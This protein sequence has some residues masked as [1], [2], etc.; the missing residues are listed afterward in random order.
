MKARVVEQWCWENERVL[1]ITVCRLQKYQL[2]DVSL[3]IPCRHHSI[4]TY[5]I[6]KERDTR[7]EFEEFVDKVFRLA[8]CYEGIQVVYHGCDAWDPT[9]NLSMISTIRSTCFIFVR[10]SICFLPEVYPICHFVYLC[11]RSNTYIHR[12][13][14]SIQFNATNFCPFPR[15]SAFN[16]HNE[17]RKGRRRRKKNENSNPQV[18]QVKVVSHKCNLCTA[19][20]ALCTRATDSCPRCIWPRCSSSLPGTGIFMGIRYSR[21][22]NKRRRISLFPSFLLIENVKLCLALLCGV[23]L[24]RTELFHLDQLMSKQY[25]LGLLINNYALTFC[26]INWYFSRS[27]ESRALIRS[28]IWIT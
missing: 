14:T 10:N 23:C 20:K 8:L 12:W 21:W 3:K 27:Q 7:A 5:R 19:S 16:I 24:S 15:L 4:Q 28:R 6:N 13:L 25:S 22:R 9:Y 18:V 17:R 11:R 2:V 26:A 1:N